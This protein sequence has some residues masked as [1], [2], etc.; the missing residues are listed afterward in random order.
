MTKKKAPKQMIKI[1]GKE[2]DLASISKD[3]KAQLTSMQRSEQYMTMTEEKLA[4]FQTAKNVYS[5]KLQDKL[6]AEAHANKK[7]NI[8]TINDKKYSY[9]DMDEETTNTI[10]SIAAV[11]K[12]IQDLQTELAF[13]KTARAAYA[14]ALKKAL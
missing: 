7:K 11:D 12:K 8:V 2:Y 4:M 13:M 14:S 3:A 6:P 5:N 9:D 10:Y 1:D